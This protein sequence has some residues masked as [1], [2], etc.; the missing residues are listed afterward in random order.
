MHL[1][2]RFDIGFGEECARHDVTLRHIYVTNHGEQLAIQK[3]ASAAIKGMVEHQGKGIKSLLAKRP[4]LS[5]AARHRDQRRK[6]WHF[7]SGRLKSK[8]VIWLCHQLCR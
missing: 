2:V 4:A 8:E 1:L 3:Q 7:W 6:V 5:G